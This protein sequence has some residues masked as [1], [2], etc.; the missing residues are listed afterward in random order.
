MIGCDNIQTKSFVSRL[1]AA[2]APD[3]QVFG[4]WSQGR[5]KTEKQHCKQT[6]N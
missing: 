4:G 1:Y 5:G 6:K 2:C 3:K